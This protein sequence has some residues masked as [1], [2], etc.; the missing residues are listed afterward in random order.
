MLVEP[1]GVLEAYDALGSAVI[2][3]ITD[4][5]AEGL[6]DT[7]LVECDSEGL[8]LI[9]IIVVIDDD[10]YG[11][12][13]THI[14]LLLLAVTWVVTVAYDAVAVTDAEADEDEE[15]LPEPL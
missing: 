1:V 5:D 15:E 4:A 6:V 12:F 2:E 13:V 11:E 10:P 7:E 14:E 8:L 9:V 3:A